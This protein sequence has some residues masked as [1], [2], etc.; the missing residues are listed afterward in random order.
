MKVGDFATLV[1]MS[2]LSV[3]KPNNSRLL[4]EVF[5][6]CHYSS[7]PLTSK[8]GLCTMKIQGTFKVSGPHKNENIM[9]YKHTHTNTQHRE[10][11]RR[12]D[13]NCH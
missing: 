13:A 8:P 7:V 10:L 5:H 1:Q 9:R 12:G 4:A 11:S 2:F 3:H 6:Q